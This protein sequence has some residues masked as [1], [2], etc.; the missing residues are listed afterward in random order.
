MVSRP[1]LLER[2]ED[3]PPR[4]PEEWATPGATRRGCGRGSHRRLLLRPRTVLPGR[5][6]RGLEG[7]LLGE[8]PARLVLGSRAVGPPTR[9][10]GLPGR[11]LGPDA[12]GPRDAL[13][14]RPSG[15]VREAVERPHLSTVYDHFPGDVRPAQRG[16][17]TT[18]L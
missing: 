11:L 15:S 1:W 3:R 4:L 16:L 14:T 5:R 7:G 10:L 13:C 12:R 18:Q 9:R 17:R 2:P 6:R 8:G